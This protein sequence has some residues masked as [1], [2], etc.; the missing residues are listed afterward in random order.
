MKKNITLILVF[1]TF[2]F[3]E[4]VTQEGTDAANFLKL[5]T[6]ISG[7]GMGGARVA[8]AN[9]ISDIGYNPASISFTKTSDLYFSMRDYLVDIKIGSIGYSR[10][11][12]PT[13]YIGLY[14]FYLDSGDIERTTLDSPDGGIGY[15]KVQDLV[16]SGIYSKVVTD[17]L[18]LGVSL[19]Y[20]Q[21]DLW[22]TSFKT[23]AFDL[24]SIFDT[25]IYGFVLGMSVSNFGPEI[26]YSG[27]GLE[28]ENLDLLEPQMWATEK[29]NLP[30]IFRLGI[31]NELIGKNSIFMKDSFQKLVVEADA[32]SPSD[33]RLYGSLGLEYSWNE[34]LYVRA[35]KYLNHHTAGLAFGAGIKYSLG[36]FGFGLNYAFSNYGMLESTSQ[37]SM[38]LIF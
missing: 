14:L 17:R 28:N 34:M 20:V 35:G 5:E 3:S 22:T 25:G 13:D 18:R 26:Q 19:K 4:T 32:V 11:I 23:V 16:L 12:S 37:Y 27:E 6:G 31:S 21:E 9:N 33:S 7:I 38:N 2:A 30:L 1:L 10:K 29:Y 15:Y 36:L 24:G 8:S